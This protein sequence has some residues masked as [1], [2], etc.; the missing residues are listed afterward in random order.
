MI[1]PQGNFYGTTYSGGTLDGGVVFQLMSPAAGQTEWSYN[2]LVFFASSPDTGGPS[3]PEARLLYA[4][5]ALYGTTTSDSPINGGAVF[6]VAP[7]GFQAVNIIW[8]FSPPPLSF[9]T[10]SFDGAFPAG[11]LIADPQGNLYGTTVNSNTADNG[12]V[13]ELIKPASGTQ[14]TE[15]LLWTFGQT[16]NDGLNPYSSLLYAYGNLYGTTANGG[17]NAAGAIFRVAP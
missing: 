7:S 16:A 5:G 12:T 14:W 8:A 2:P 3:F 6:Q 17:A 13:Y 1:D 4:N 11:G 9:P 10:S 15:Q